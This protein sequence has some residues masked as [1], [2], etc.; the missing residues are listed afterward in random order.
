MGYT[1]MKDL[2]FGVLM[3]VVFLIGYILLNQINMRGIEDCSKNYDINYC[4][5][6]M[7]R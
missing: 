2:M 4:K 3:V 6:V 1:K 5:Q 7:T